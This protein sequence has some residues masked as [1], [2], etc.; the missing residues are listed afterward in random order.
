M[1]KEISS[2]QEKLKLLE[3]T[4]EIDK[5]QNIHNDMAGILQKSKI[6]TEGLETMIDDIQDQQTNVEEANELLL[7]MDHGHD[8]TTLDMELDASIVNDSLP[9]VPTKQPVLEYNSC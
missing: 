7:H 3:N 1:K 2:L 4:I 8:E 6:N 5:L 9:N